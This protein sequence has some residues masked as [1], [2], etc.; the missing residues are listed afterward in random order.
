MYP[1]RTQ[2][3]GPPVEY[4]LPYDDDLDVLMPEHDRSRLIEIMNSTKK[5]KR[6]WA[7]FA[8]G[9]ASSTKFYFRESTRAGD[10][11][12]NWPFIDV[13]GYSENS[14][15]IWFEAPV[16]KN[17]IFPL[18][19]RP[20]ASLWLWSPRSIF[21]YYRSLQK[22]YRLYNKSSSF[23][24]ECF[25]QRYSH[26][27]ERQKHEFKVVN[28]TQLHN[29]YRYIRRTCNETRCLEHLMINNA[30]LYTLNIDKD[31]FADDFPS[32]DADWDDIVE[33]LV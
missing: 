32:R 33:E 18:I 25:Q 1:F 23:D 10:W 16:N 13:F 19:L 11:N 6:S 31:P 5:G 21:G 8:R 4:I 17:Y 9:R 7:V 26:R 14:T 28:C 20:T 2:S 24:Q 30:L 15:H 22:Y 3:T 12:W 27:Y 29:T